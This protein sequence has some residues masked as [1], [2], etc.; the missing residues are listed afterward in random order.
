MIP[1]QFTEKQLL[2]HDSY[3]TWLR[4]I[5]T[6]EHNGNMVSVLGSCRSTGIEGF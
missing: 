5:T 1:K 6:Q 4:E 2:D 3:Q